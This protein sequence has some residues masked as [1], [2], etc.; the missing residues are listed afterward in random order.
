MKNFFKKIHKK[1]PQFESI[2][3]FILGNISGVSG[4]LFASELIEIKSFLVF[5]SIWIYLFSRETLIRAKTDKSKKMSNSLKNIEY[6]S[7]KLRGDFEIGKY[8]MDDALKYCEAIL[9][10]ESRLPEMR[11]YND[12]K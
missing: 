8:S 3:T 7:T 4:S 12:R 6:A 9:E 1:N 5:K 11:N 10:L 2:I